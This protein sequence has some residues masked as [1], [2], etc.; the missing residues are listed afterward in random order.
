M[1][2]NVSSGAGTR[3]YAGW[4]AYCAAKAAVDQLTRVVALEEHAHGLAAYA[5][6]PGVV[7]TDMQETIRATDEADFPE[8]ARFRQ[9]AVDG[10]FNSASWVAEHLLGLAF[11]GEHPAQVT[12]R[13][14]AEPRVSRAQ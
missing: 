7:D 4:A 12:V 10:N 5:V 3:P 11:G 8:V 2:I 13:I 14:P 6:A 1:L 9:L